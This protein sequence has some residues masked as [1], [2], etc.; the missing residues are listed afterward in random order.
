MAVSQAVNTNFGKNRVQ[1]HND[2]RSWWSYETENFITYW[3][4]K[5]RNIAKTVT[6]MSELDHDEIQNIME[7]RFNDKIEIIVYVDV[8]DIKQSNI[9][10]EETFINDNKDTKIEG[11]KM[12][13]YFNGDH[14]HL[15]QQIKKGIAAIYLNSILVGSNLQEMV[16]NAVLLNLPEWFKKGMVAYVAAPWSIDADDELRDLMIVEEGKY[17]DFDKLSEDHPKIAGHSFWHFL[18][19]KYGRSSI[20]NILYLTRINRNIESSFIYVLS[21][22]FEDIIIEWQDFYRQKYAQ[23]TDRFASYD[24]EKIDLQNKDYQVVSL[25]RLSPDGTKLAYVYNDIGK[26]KIIL[27]DLGTEEEEKIFQYG[28][29]NTFQ[30]TDYEYPIV[31]W[32]PNGLQLSIVYEARDQLMIRKYYLADG[33]IEEQAF[34]K[35]IQRIYS[36]SYVDSDEYILSAS[37]NGFS[38]LFSFK[39]KTRQFKKITEDY[40]DDLDA[41]YTKINGKYGVLFSS[42]RES[43]LVEKE[44]L[45]SILP[46]NNYDL[47]FLP[48]G[49]KQLDRITYTPDENERFPYVVGEDNHISFISDQSGI[50]NRFLKDLASDNNG[51]SNSNLDRNII[52]HHSINGNDL[53]VYT[54]YRDGAYQTFLGIVDNEKVDAYNTPL[55]KI[56][57]E[58]DVAPVEIEEEIKEEM[59]EG[60]LFQSDFEDP[61]VI[62]PIAKRETSPIYSQE[63]FSLRPESESYKDVEPFNPSRAVASRLKFKMVELSSNIDNSVLFEGLESYLGDDRELLSQ[64]LGIRFKARLK[65]LFEDYVVEVGARYPTSL[66]GSEYYVVFENNKRLIDKKFAIYRKS[67]TLNPNVNLFPV[68]SDKKVSYLGLAQFKYPF[69]IYR[70]L[71]ATGI[72]RFDNLY[73]RVTE[74]VALQKEFLRENRIGLR[75]EYIFDNTL[76]VTLNIKNGTRYKVYTEVLNRFNLSAVDGFE[77]DASTGFTTIIGGD[78]RHYIPVAKFS[79]IALRAAGGTSFGNSRMM[80]YLGGMESALFGKF[81]NEI[82]IPGGDEFGYKALAPHL[83]GFDHNIRNGSSF[84]LFNG[85]MRVPVV[86][87]LFRKVTNS[88]LRNIQLTTFFDIGTAWHGLSPYGNDNP[89]NTVFLEATNVSVVANYY[90]DPIVMGYG[91]GF[92]TSLIGYFLKL[93]Y[94]WGIETRQVQDPKWHFSMGMDF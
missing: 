6:Q 5:G 78:F 27:R 68:I 48:S 23:E 51:Y 56:K 19:Q 72:L 46:L 82:P 69:D 37:D 32:H 20:S 70:S 8:T 17:L 43:N 94:A 41:V 63:I 65:D 90:R 81:N 93:D 15:R 34:P 9:G 28:F 84:L 30:Q 83:R 73:P 86:K 25:L 53:S 60:Y 67:N 36:L 21:Q 12:F 54:L 44:N 18:D 7:H 1:F 80:Y 4:G 50:K 14:K 61:D 49:S 16:Q 87:H 13:V 74:P 62:E 2:F 89:L 40:H 79:V 75:L 88:F 10:L 29:R 33:E 42:N 22:D 24:G 47:F 57:S 3:Y 35:K 77:F 92:R 52:R 91:L 58:T 66:N 64:P 11:N 85:E 59:K 71:S 55:S 39:F 26:Y 31:E 45:D 76:D 38:D